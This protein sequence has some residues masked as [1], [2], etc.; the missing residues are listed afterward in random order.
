[1]ATT[2]LAHAQAKSIGGRDGRIETN[3]NVLSLELTMP[4]ALGGRARAGATNPEQLF[5][6][7]YAACFGNAVIGMAKQAKAAVG[8]ISV[9]AAVDMFMNEEQLP[10]LG[11]ALHVNL[12]GITQEQA[13]D[14]V[15]KAHHMC[16]YS[17][18]IR[19]NVD[20]KLTITTEDVTVAA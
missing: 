12:P 18:A 3:D 2:P 6:A 4:R 9:D 10:T 17:R 20:V 13:E 15:N 19:G 16:P 11:V 5:A 1:M 8:E 14:V 7:G